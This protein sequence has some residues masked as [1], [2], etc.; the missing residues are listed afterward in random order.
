MTEYK[1]NPKQDKFINLLLLFALLLCITLLAL[2]TRQIIG[3]QNYIQTSMEHFEEVIH[4]QGNIHEETSYQEY[5]GSISVTEDTPVLGNLQ[6]AN[7]I[8]V[9]FTDFQ[10]PY[11]ATALAQI[12]QIIK[13]NP[14]IALIHKDY[15]LVFH[16]DARLAAVAGKCAV[17]QGEFWEYAKKLFL[18]Q[19]NLK[20]DNLQKVASGIG[21]DSDQFTICLNDKQTQESVQLD[22]EEGIGNKIDGTPMYLIGR[23]THE[24]QTLKIIGYRSSLSDLETVL[25]LL[26][27]KNEAEMRISKCLLVF[28]ILSVALSACNQDKKESLGQPQEMSLELEERFKDAERSL[29]DLSKLNLNWLQNNSGWLNYK[30]IPNEGGEPKFGFTRQD[31][32]YL[33]EKGLVIKGLQIVFSDALDKEVQRFVINP[34]GYR[35]ELL[36]LRENGLSAQT[37]AIPYPANWQAE[38][39]SWAYMDLT[40]FRSMK[41]FII[42]IEAKEKNL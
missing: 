12:N 23:F 19:E 16:T 40:I 25:S 28:L 29:S 37:Y 14:D 24:G 2:L 32:W 33:L 39:L 17:R 30:V 8:I 10:C 3:L 20:F 42:D 11:C 21:L 36:E 27:Q 34:D 7:V 26:R 22:L 5:S 31:C 1:N 38:N 41:E 9:E 35:G 4:Q 18:N 6:E 15:P 13:E